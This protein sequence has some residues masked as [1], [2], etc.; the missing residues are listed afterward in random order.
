MMDL[1]AETASTP[2]IFGLD[3]WSLIPIVP[4]LIFWEFPIL[5]YIGIVGVIFF[6]MLNFFGYS[7][8]VAWRVFRRAFTGKVKYRTLSNISRRRFIND[9]R[10][11]IRI[12]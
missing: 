2:K 9:T 4:G 6:T 11:G 8:R 1:W 12:I 5:L 3:I 10:P 7:I